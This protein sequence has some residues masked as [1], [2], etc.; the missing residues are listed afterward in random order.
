M[1][2]QDKIIVVTGAANG[3]GR[4][5]CVAFAAAGAKAIA[6]VDCDA[7]GLDSIAI[8][9]NGMPITVDV[10][11]EDQIA[12]MITYVEE[13]LGPICS[14]PTRASLHRVA[15]RCPMTTGSGCGTST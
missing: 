4:A 11:S 3:I 5:L 8:E 1:D 6:C 14:V 12:A 10:T 7:A 15:S 2:V 9:I 13:T